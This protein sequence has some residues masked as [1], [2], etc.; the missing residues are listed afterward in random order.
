MASDL[1]KPA[2]RGNTD[3][4]ASVPMSEVG[5]DI[6]P[7]PQIVAFAKENGEPVVDEAGNRLK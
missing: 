5:L 1:D 7:D 6:L 2:S 4:D 3:G